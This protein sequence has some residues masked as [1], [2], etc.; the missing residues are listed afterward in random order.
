MSTIALRIEIPGYRACAALPTLVDLLRDH[1]AGASFLV[2]FGN[3]WLGRSPARQCRHLLE[4]VRAA[5]FDLGILGWQP[6]QWVERADSAPATWVSKQLDQART[7]FEKLFGHTPRLTAAP[8]WQGNPHSLRLTQRLGFSIS[9][10]TRGR[11][12]FIPVWNGE[13]VRCPQIPVTLPTFEELA[14]SSDERTADAVDALLALS[15][16]PSPAG[17]VFNLTAS[18]AIGKAPQ[19]F[20]R[21]L[22][23]WRAQ[24]YRI[25]SL[26]IFATGLVID[27]LPRHEIVIGTVPGHPRPLLLQGDEFLAEWR[28]PA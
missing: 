18:R 21:L 7:A 24:G 13:I 4:Q 11:H 9:S 22:A 3:D 5:G 26:D 12:P 20:E 15:A 23:G 25:V 2:G 16:K 17:H 14:N 19:H 10:D 6:T 28:I 1:E 27:Q 8:G